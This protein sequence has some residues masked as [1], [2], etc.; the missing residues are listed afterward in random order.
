MWL[1]PMALALLLAPLVTACFS[2]PFQPPAADAALWEKPGASSKDVLASML[3][4]G[5]KNG[6]GIDPNASFQE[7]AQRFV[8]MKRSGYTRRDGFDVC[9]L[10]TQ[11]PLKACESAQ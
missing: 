1:K 4:C 8:C 6:S 10:R 5:E 9:A 11:E 3:A 2:E 7:R